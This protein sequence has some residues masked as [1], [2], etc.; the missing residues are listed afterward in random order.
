M[1]TRPNQSDAVPTTDPPPALA[2]WLAVV[3]LTATMT[4]VSTYQSLRRYEELRSGWSWD[5]AY[6]NQW[7]WALTQGDGTL[8]VRPVSA[9]AQ[10]GPSVWKMNY[11]SPM[12]FALVPF[13]RLFPDPR[14]L[15]V[16]QNIVFWWVI[17]AAYGLVRSESRSEGA[18]L[19]AAALVPLTPLFWPLVWNDFRELQLVAPFVLW[20]VRG[21]RERSARRAALGIAGMLACRQE[22]AVAVMTFAILPPRRPESLARHPPMAA[23]D[24]AR[25][26]RLDPLRLLRLPEIRGRPRGA[27]FVHRPVPRAQ[28]VARRDAP[29]VLRGP[30]P[31]HGRLGVADVPGARGGDPGPALDLEPVQ[32]PMG[33]AVPRDA[34]VAPRPVRH[35]DGG[36]G[37]GR[38]TD[39][40]R[41]AGDLAAAPPRG[42]GLAGDG[43]ARLGRGLRASASG[44]SPVAWRPC[45]RSSIARRPRRSGPGSAR[46]APT[47]PSSPITRSPPPLVAPLAL[48]LHHGR[49]PAAGISRTSAPSSA[50]C[51]SG[52]TGRHL[53]ALLDQGFSVVHRGPYLTIARRGTIS[54]AGISEFFPIPREQILRDK[55]STSGTHVRVAFRSRGGSSVALFSS[56]VDP[57]RVESRCVDRVCGPVASRSREPERT[58]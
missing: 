35:A 18:A 46:S 27:G 7:Y 56:A 26:A 38:G 10:E 3:L 49:Q 28:G 5:L 1:S 11:L 24:G 14:T 30:D 22:F 57:A 51:S 25:R 55:M 58:P 54:L 48:Q 45:P 17:P 8:T 44:T 20:A 34:R 40:L 12:R 2:G 39:R 16:L 31:G 50:G 23:G 47:T 4:T 42:P 33:H 43:L 15:I 32:R 41:A 29:D 21:V 19:S 13:Y 37:P 9:Y 36:H 52:T 6:Y 53:K